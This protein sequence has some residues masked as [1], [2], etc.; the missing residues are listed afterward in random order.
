MFL[1]SSLLLENI[2][3]AAIGDRERGLTNLGCYLKGFAFLNT[4]SAFIN[5]K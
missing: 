5:N 2:F 3:L 1:E 4:M